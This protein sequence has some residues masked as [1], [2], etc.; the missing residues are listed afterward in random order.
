MSIELQFRDKIDSGALRLD[1]ND[2]AVW[3]FQ[4]NPMAD[5]SP[6][7][8]KRSISNTMLRQGAHIAASAYDNRRLRFD[9][10]V[11]KTTEDLLAAEIQKLNRELDRE[12]NI[13][14][15]QPNGATNPVYFRTFRSPAYKLKIHAEAQVNRLRCSLDV[16]AEPF[17]YGE[18]VEVTGTIAGDPTDG[19][20]PLGFQI[21][22]TDGD[23]PT[24]LWLRLQAATLDE[25]VIGAR[26]HGV[27]A[28][29]F[30]QA[31]DMTQGT[32]TTTQANDVLYSGAGNNF[33]R[34]T[35]G[36]PTMTTRLTWD[37]A[38]GSGNDDD[39]R[40]T[41]RAF[42]RVK[43]SGSTDD[44]NVRMLIG[45]GAITTAP[46]AVPKNTDQQ[47]LDLGLVHIPPAPDAIFDGMSGAILPTEGAAIAFQAER[48]SGSENLDWDFVVLIP[49]DEEL[50][51]ANFNPTG[52]I[53]SIFDGPNDL[54][55]HT[56][57]LSTAVQERGTVPLVGSIPLVTPNQ[58]NL[59]IVLQRIAN[60]LIATDITFTARYWPRW[61]YVRP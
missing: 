52:S 40:G 38:P 17:A 58:T 21:V 46:V 61:L 55:F 34:T 35:F 44:I 24:P 16:L 18:K 26:R 11:E 14:K 1:L 60:H 3:K 7:V 48:V 33:S 32:D 10:V 43:R 2:G 51:I 29:Y 28:L 13:L 50:A 45:V 4:R 8:L 56:N 6:P 41:Y 12:V 39:Y 19:A 31:E 36:T 23:I 22:A 15:Y 47:M 20:D 5:F 25:V 57:A 9:L 53:A 30:K 54:A 49:A 42:A 37:P 27:P 59:Y